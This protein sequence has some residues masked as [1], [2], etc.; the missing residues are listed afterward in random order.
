[1]T[2]IYH[3]T[4]IRNLA[5]ILQDGR[6]WCDSERIRRQIIS[7]GIAHEHI[8]QRRARRIV[9][10]CRGGVLAD[11]VPF[12]FAPRSP[13]LYTIHK[14]NVAGYSEGQTPVLHLVSSVENVVENA[15]PFTFSNGHAEMATAQFFELTED[16]D[17][18]DWAVMRSGWWNDTDSNSNRKWKRQAEFLV[19]HSFPVPLFDEIGVISQAVAAE[20]EQILTSVG[21][22][23]SVI[24]RPNW[25]Y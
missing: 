16:L 19:H 12:Y 6:L 4:H 20:V 25:Y 13:M 7:V 8:K 14:G 5:S 22:T 23:M 1:M 11:Y 3:I 18:I 10:N 21:R 24:P 15:L 17:K 2:A 9:P